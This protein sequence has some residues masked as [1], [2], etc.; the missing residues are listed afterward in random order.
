LAARKRIAHRKS[1][2]ETSMTVCLVER[3][4]LIRS[5]T[6]LKSP[7]ADFRISRARA[8]PCN[9]LTLNVQVAYVKGNH[10]SQL[11]ALRRRA[12]ASYRIDNNDVQVAF[13]SLIYDS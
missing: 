13:H 8:S 5:K 1:S 2:T 6:K 3:R 9:V 11:G 4:E 12:P 7:R 10:F